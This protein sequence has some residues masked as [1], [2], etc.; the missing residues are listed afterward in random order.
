MPTRGSAIGAGSS[1]FGFVGGVGS[2][3]SPSQ[4]AAYPQMRS[5]NGTSSKGSGWTEGTKYLLALVVL[6]AF[7][8]VAL[9][10]GFRESHGG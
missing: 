7:V 5:V 3:D 8:L 9:R 2:P 10:H 1:V 6:E 4:K